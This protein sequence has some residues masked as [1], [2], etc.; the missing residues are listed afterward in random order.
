M[1]GDG[2]AEAADRA[3]WQK[4]PE[5]SSVFML[6]VMTLISLRLG[7]SASRLVLYGIAAY[8]LLFAPKARRM[9]RNYLRRVLKLPS[10]AALGW[11]HLYRHFLSFAS[12]IHDRVY[13]LN[14]RFDLFD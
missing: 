4:N 14:D 12:A 1:K 10:A 11:S 9:S 5:R 8:F 3:E 13:L 2:N 6:R 7:R